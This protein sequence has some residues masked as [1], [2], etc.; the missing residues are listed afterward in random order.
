MPLFSF[1]SVKGERKYMNKSLQTSSLSPDKILMLRESS[2]AA[3][4]FIAAVSYFDF[5]SWLA[6]SPA[7]IDSICTSLGIKKR[8]ADVMLTLFKA[9]G[10][11]K[12][13]NHKFDLTDTSRK[14]LLNTSDHNLSS[15]VSSLKN[16]PISEEMKNTLLTGRPANWAAAK[17]G[18]NWTASMKDEAFAESFTAGMNS[19]GAY[20]AKGLLK[21][22]DLHDCHKILDIGGGSGIYSIILLKNNPDLS[23]AVFEKPPVDK[24]ALYSINK[25]Q[26]DDRIKVI[27]GDIFKESLPGGYDVHLISH[28]LHDW[29]FPEVRKILQN[30]YAALNPGGKV[31]IHDA[32]LHRRKTGPL[33]VAEYSVLLMFLS[34]GKCYSLTEMEEM[35]KEIGFKNIEYKPTVYNRSVI[36]AIK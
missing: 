15:Y 10:F 6:E 34:E 22:L 18:K 29:D 24:V 36:T 30:S 19:R 16:R 23:A 31:V 12:E 20:L 32:H 9:Y 5:F 8:C 21:A 35:L 14:Y 13:I 4:L 11:I 25:H 7:D 27:T 2:F 1:P 17:D 33:S 28:V 3:D 26:F